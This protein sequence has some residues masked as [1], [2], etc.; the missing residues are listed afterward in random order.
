[1]K[2]S[3]FLPLVVAKCVK[4]F[5]AAVLILVPLLTHCL[6]LEKSPGR[7]GFAIHSEPVS[8]ISSLKASWALQANLGPALGLLLAS[9]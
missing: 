7:S 9:L 5:R 3:E 8:G 4:R 2:Q 6:T 1:M